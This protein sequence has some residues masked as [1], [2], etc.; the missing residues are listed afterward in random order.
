VHD[1][2]TQSESVLS[3]LGALPAAARQSAN[4]DTYTARVPSFDATLDQVHGGPH[5]HFGAL[6]TW[7]M[8]QEQ[9]VGHG[10]P[11]AY[12]R[13]YIRECAVCQKYRRT[14]TNDR[15]PH[16]TRHLKVP[17]PRSTVGIDGFK[18]TPPDKHGNSY[19]HVLVNHFTKHVY[20]H[21]S[22]LQNA[23]GAANAILT[24]IS[25]FGRF[26]KLIS[27]PGSDYTADTVLQ[28]NRYFGIERA[29]SLVDRHESNGV[30]STNRE[31]KRHIQTLV[32]DKR[33]SDRWSEPQV[34][35]LITFHINNMRSSE[36]G[37]SAFDCTF[38]SMQ[39]DFF[40]SLGVESASLTS[41]SNY[42][43]ELT[44]DIAA[45]QHSSKDFQQTLV[46]KRATDL[47]KPRNSWSSGDLVFVDNL[48]PLHKLQAPRLGPYEV[49][50]HHR[51]DVTLRDLITSVTKDFHVDRLSLFAGSPAT[52]F[53]LAM[54]D[55]N[56]HLIE[57]FL[58]YRGDVNT[59]QTMQFLI[60]FT[61]DPD[62]VWR[63]YDKDISDTAPFESFCKSLP[64]LE[65]LLSTAIQ[66]SA[67]AIALR[68]QRTDTTHH[69]G[70]TIFVDLRSQDI[71][72]HE[73]YNSI[74]IS[75]KDIVPRYSCMRVG[76]SAP[77]QRG[78]TTGTRVDLLDDAF[79]LVHRV[80]SHFLRYNGTLTATSDFPN[81]SKVVTRAFA[82]AHPYVPLNHS[83]H[84]AMIPADRLPVL[85]HVPTILST[86][87]ETLRI[88]SYNV[89]G[90]ASA[91]RKGFLDQ[92]KTMKGGPPD[93]LLLQE[94]RAHMQDEAQFEKR[95]SIL[96]Y[97]HFIMV[98]GAPHHQSGV[99]VVSKT[100]FLLLPNGPGVERGRA[101]AIAVEGVTLVNIY[102]PIVCS[103]QQ[104]MID[105]RVQFDN[106]VLAWLHTLPDQ[107]L[108]GGDFNLAADA[109]LDIVLR[110][111]ASDPMQ[112]FTS[113]VEH[114]L[115]TSLIATEY[116]D[117]F[118]ALHP[119]NRAYTTFP[120]G[121]WQGMSIRVDYFMA[122]PLLF[123][124][125]T[126]C[127]I[128][129]QTPVSDHAGVEITVKRP[130]INSSFPFE[131]GS[132][133]SLMVSHY[134]NWLPPTEH[135]YPRP[136]PPPTNIKSST[137]RQRGGG[138]ETPQRPVSHSTQ[139]LVARGAQNSEQRKD[140]ASSL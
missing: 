65:P 31:L 57:R 47:S 36:S 90:L 20:L 10:I 123:P 101:I 6:A 17:G 105:R 118:R 98:A 67:N 9:F 76:R 12:V 5:L 93:V 14:L 53:D 111:N 29:L 112:L 78:I 23:E 81:G 41:T 39:S 88:V 70:D 138:R 72:E 61:G 2:L 58:A 48:A 46:A 7:R 136:S 83:K 110:R 120:R 131:S 127:K 38:G 4:V 13:F 24:Y 21:P 99:A 26:T 113:D 32:H 30:E 134:N 50:A 18:M 84:R 71:Y 79:Q 130:R 1:N 80:D 34:L 86:D 89:N 132:P 100:P 133:T 75:G 108:L 44:K 16:V 11:M 85:A 64:Q 51:N 66:A 104:L 82:T 43:V 28:L 140:R 91:L 69:E 114:N 97:T 107:I 63:T 56:Q 59:R 109:T 52:A 96:G 74:T 95:F 62:P 125:I 49:V 54:R 121:S 73:W 68:K 3:T 135:P 137:K 128:Q 139:P 119:A 19:I 126:A 129:P 124:T 102:A 25:L 106:A 42:V 117:V 8:L 94:T 22:K 37:Y 87:P 35:G 27:D 77:S 116:V 60:S 122:S 55:N 103:K 40:K 33:F 15:I 115:Y 45:I 92:L